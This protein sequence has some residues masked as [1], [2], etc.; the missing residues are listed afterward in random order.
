MKNKKEKKPKEKI[1][2][3]DSSHISLKERFKNNTGYILTII[4]AIV[5]IAILI[6]LIVKNPFKKNRSEIHSGTQSTEDNG[7]G[8]LG[9]DDL[10]KIY[11]DAG[12]DLSTETEEE[13]EVSNDNVEEVK[14]D[15][16]S[17]LEKHNDEEIEKAKKDH[18]LLNQDLTVNLIMDD[19]IEQTKRYNKYIDA[20][21]GLYEDE[22][23]SDEYQGVRDFNDKVVDYLIKGKN[24]TPNYSGYSCDDYA[25]VYRYTA[26][27]D[28]A[29]SILDWD[30]YQYKSILKNYFNIGHPLI[31]EG[32]NLS[33]NYVFN[34]NK[35]F[36]SF[37]PV[38]SLTFSSNGKVYKAW[39]MEGG[40]QEGYVYTMLDLELLK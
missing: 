7:D 25:A 24:F 36:D 22:Y 16:R 13:S 40:T 15:T 37:N 11:A 10:K 21:G 23:L 9:Y 19:I 34:D 29:F 17:P 18:I 6:V 12:I 32:S 38:F 2:I 8:K 27:N 39:I 14:K 4:V 20:H 35:T 28:Y 1:E 3:V 26:F 30:K 5:L 33:L 31:S